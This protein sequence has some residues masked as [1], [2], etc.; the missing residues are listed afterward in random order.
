[1]RT[2]A[3][4]ISTVSA[5][6]AIS[7]ISQKGMSILFTLD[8]FDLEHI[9]QAAGL[10]PGRVLFSPGDKAVLTL[11]LKKGEDPLRMAS[12]LVESYQALIP[13]EAAKSPG[14]EGGGG[15]D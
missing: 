9:S 7:D 11:K 1:M 13:P 10:F 2:S 4:F 12:K 6:C 14:P 3:R 5:I 8:E 15:K